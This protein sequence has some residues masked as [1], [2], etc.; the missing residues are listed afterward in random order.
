[1]SLIGKVY[2]KHVLFGERQPIF[3]LFADLEHT[4]E[5]VRFANQVE[6]HEHHATVQA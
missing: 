4:F 1:M 6:F 3:V 2:V 5:K